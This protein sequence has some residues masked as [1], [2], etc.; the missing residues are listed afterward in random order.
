MAYIK[1]SKDKVGDDMIDGKWEF[2]CDIDPTDVL[3]ITTIEDARNL[4]YFDTR[5]TKT[6]IKVAINKKELS[7]L[8]ERLMKLRAAMK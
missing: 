5:P 2:R 4:V 8:I 1:R 7:N 6:T 3:E